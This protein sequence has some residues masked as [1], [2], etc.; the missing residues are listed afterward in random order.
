MLNP[1][2]IN[3][4]IVE[5]IQS[6]ASHNYI[7]KVI[8]VDVKKDFGEY[9]KNVSR[10]NKNYTAAEN[11]RPEQNINAY[12]YTLSPYSPATKSTNAG[13][14]HN[15][16]FKNYEESLDSADET[17]DIVEEEQGNIPAELHGK[18]FY[19][20]VNTP[21]KKFGQTFLKEFSSEVQ[22]RIK[23]AYHVGYNREPGT[24]VDLVF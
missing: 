5:I 16:R 11:P 20:I 7:R 17:Y 4:G 14:V 24:L 23:K 22:K 6:G 10:E 19:F 12:N 21:G 13:R 15:E 18:G 2:T 9:E 1:V 8:E 3:Q